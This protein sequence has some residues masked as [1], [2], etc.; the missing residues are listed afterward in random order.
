[1][2]GNVV[3]AIRSGDE[4]ALQQFRSDILNNKDVAIE[5]YSQMAKADPEDSVLVREAVPILFMEKTYA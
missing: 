5:F 3:V 4:K 2:F 1:M